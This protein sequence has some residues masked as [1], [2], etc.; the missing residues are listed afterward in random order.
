MCAC[1]RACVNSCLA[2]D[3]FWFMGQR[4]D[5]RMTRARLVGACLAVLLV[6]LALV[7]ILALGAVRRYR[8]MLIQAKVNQ[9]RSRYT[10]THAHTHTHLSE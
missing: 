8:A 4:C 1:V 7:A 6:T 10:H 5:V 9:T 3:H 2:G